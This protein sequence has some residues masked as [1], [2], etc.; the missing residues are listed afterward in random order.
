MLESP[1][2]LARVMGLT[3]LAQHHL[4]LVLQGLHV[5]R[6][7]QALRFWRGAA[8]VSSSPGLPCPSQS[9]GP[10]GGEHSGLHLSPPAPEGGSLHTSGS[11]WVVGGQVRGTRKSLEFPSFIP[12]YFSG[13]AKT[14]LP[15]LKRTR[16][17]M[18]ANSVGSTANARNREMVSCRKRISPLAS[19]SRLWELPAAT[20]SGG[21]SSGQLSRGRDHCMAPRRKS[22]LQASSRRITCAQRGREG[23]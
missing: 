19:A 10:L 6:I 15:G 23:G 11:V 22:S 13:W 7:L 2:G 17:F 9:A 4:G 18:H 5:L 8:A 1:H 3:V 20:A 14:Q 21:A 12:N 16:A